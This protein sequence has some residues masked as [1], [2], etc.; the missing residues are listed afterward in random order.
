MQMY[1]NM[2]RL[3]TTYI[4]L[5]TDM[6]LYINFLFFQC[7][8]ISLIGHFQNSSLAYRFAKIFSDLLRIIKGFKREKA[9]AISFPLMFFFYYIFISGNPW[10]TLVK[11]F[12][13]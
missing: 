1:I 11:P 10:I 6:K 8:K 5:H 4:V 12:E 3:N 7:I 13:L 2:K 9:K